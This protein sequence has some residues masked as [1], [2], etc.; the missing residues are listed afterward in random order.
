MSAA[1]LVILMS[2]GAAY[3]MSASKYLVVRKVQKALPSYHINVFEEAMKNQNYRR[4]L[5]TGP[6]S[7]LVLMSIPVGGEVGDELHM[8]TEQT[9]FFLSGTGEAILDGKKFPVIPGDVVVVPAGIRH[10]FRNTGREPLKI[11]TVYAP[12]N[13]LDGRV[14]KTRA[15]ADADRADQAVGGPE[16]L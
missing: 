13:H 9:I 15:D 16:P 6:Q 10:N 1:A 3:A 7:Q 2:A 4:V 12:A 14:H 8:R 5:H 11:Y